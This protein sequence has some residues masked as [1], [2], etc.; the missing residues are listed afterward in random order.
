MHLYR[1]GRAS[2]FCRRRP[3]CTKFTICYR[4]IFSF[5]SRLPPR[6]GSHLRS[7]TKGFFA[8]KVDLTNMT[9]A[10]SHPQLTR[11]ITQ[12][13]VIEGYSAQLTATLNGRGSTAEHIALDFDAAWFDDESCKEE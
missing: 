9:S 8:Q 11:A 5:S 13:N 2:S 10:V 6:S 7:P 1:Y 12:L 3:S 4:R